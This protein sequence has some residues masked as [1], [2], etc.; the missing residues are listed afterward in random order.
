MAL[1]Q[2]SRYI[3]KK[4]KAIHRI[5]GKI[6]VSVIKQDGYLRYIIED[7]GVGRNTLNSPLQ[8]EKISYGIDMS[9]DRVKLFNNE[10]KASV[11]ITDLL[12]NGKPAGTKVEVLLKIQ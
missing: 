5:S 12:D 3:L 9:N 1:I 10:E 6:Y 8:K 11:Q 2:F 4:S 7:N